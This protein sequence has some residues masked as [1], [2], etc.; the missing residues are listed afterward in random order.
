MKKFIAVLAFF[1][2]TL[3]STDAAFAQEA[4]QNFQAIAKHKTHEITKQFKVDG[5]SQR[6]IY[7]AYMLRE[8]KL[9]AMLRNNP[10]TAADTKA[11][12]TE[13][14]SKLK[15]VL[16]EEQIKKLKQMDIE[17]PKTKK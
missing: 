3:L 6:V 8:R 9:A 7:N 12:D 16:T 4:R 15:T 17:K 14:Y 2:V 11:I 13:L 10:N 1:T 5:K